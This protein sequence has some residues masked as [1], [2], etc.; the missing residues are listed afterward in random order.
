M[1]TS[2]PSSSPPAVEVVALLASSLLGVRH[3][4][5]PRGGRLRPATR[6]LLAFAAVALLSAAV[7]FVVATRIA[8]A[9]DAGRAA[10]VAAGK[11]AWAFRARLV[12]LDLD[13]IT[14]GGLGLGLT[15]VVCGLARARRERQPAAV[16]LGNRPG[17]D[18]AVDGLPGGSVALVAPTDAADGFAVHVPPG[19]HAELRR[20]GGGGAAF[21][22]PTTLPVTPDLHL[23]LRHGAL[24]FHVAAV[25]APRSA[26]APLV[27]AIERRPAAFL[28]ASAVAHLLAI[29][30]LRTIPPEAGTVN[31][32]DADGE[33][34]LGHAVMVSIDDPPPP[35]PISGGGSD[36]EVGG[37][38]PAMALASGA[39]GAATATPDPGTR[40]IA[41][42]ETPADLARQQALDEARRAGVLGSTLFEADPFAAVTGRADFSSGF[43]AI[44]QIG[45]TFGT[46][47]GAPK[48]FGTGQSGFGPG[49]GGDQWGLVR[50]GNGGTIR[51]GRG[52]GLGYGIGSGG[53]G[54]PP[55]SC[56]GRNH[57]AAVPP[58]LGKPTTSGD[59][60]PN[61]IR[62]YVK[63]QVARISYCYE[64]Q[65]LA[66]PGLQGTVLATFRIHANGHVM[67]SDASGV[68]GDVARCIAGVIENIQF[69]HL[70]DDGVFEIKYPFV[71]RPTGA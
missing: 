1:S 28:A 53:C 45:G 59:I 64:S 67:S 19:V 47:S 42:R 10:W 41:R 24:T 63:R 9:N 62:R 71:L 37:G 15:A 70:A 16:R 32:L 44:D 39:T 12:P 33:L 51:D 65:L 25:P 52:A 20:P 58:V 11:P 23:R 29:A 30:F 26:P 50:A 38:G 55:G 18:F 21:V 22:G 13:A 34:G 43:D 36:R 49:G 56:R 7:A 66:K 2:S 8:A 6:G 3:A 31:P 40:T 5:D 4:I 27:A 54:V 68:D 46:G 14:F 57:V 60:D 69:P 48:G 35:P 61:T 17:D